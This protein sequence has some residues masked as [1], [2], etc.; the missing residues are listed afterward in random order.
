LRARIE[1]K[2]VVVVVVVSNEQYALLTDMDTAK[3]IF[4]ISDQGL[5]S[6][7]C[8]HHFI[9]GSGE[10]VKSLDEAILRVLII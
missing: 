9:P 4:S 3:V 1:N 2:F 7:L 5:W 10:H 6:Y 8:R